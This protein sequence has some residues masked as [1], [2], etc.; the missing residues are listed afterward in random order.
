MAVFIKAP[1]EKTRS[2]HSKPLPPVDLNAS[3]VLYVGHLMTI[4]HIGHSTVYS[5]IRNNIL[6]KWDGK[7]GRR[8]YWRTETIRQ[9]LNQ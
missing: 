8:P 2:G 4:Y 7:V 6:P 9:H 1:N 5:Y 3:G